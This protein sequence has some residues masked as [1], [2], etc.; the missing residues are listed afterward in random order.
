MK[1]LPPLLRIALVVAALLPARAALA[2]DGLRVG[3]FVETT[4]AGSKLAHPAPDHPVYYEPFIIGYRELGGV[5]TYWQRPPPPPDAVKHALIQAL[6]AQGYQVAPPQ[7]PASLVLVF[8]WGIV[9]PAM[10][11]LLDPK[12]EAV[13]RIEPVNEDAM[14]G[15][16]VGEPWREIYP[17]DNPDAREFIANLHAEESS[18]YFLIISALDARA[19]AQHRQVLLWRAHVT[20]LYWGHYFD[21]VLGTL[22]TTSAPLLGTRMARPQM[23]TVPASPL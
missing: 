5:L 23:L 2:D 17:T 9:D 14:L 6:A 21:Q 19:F 12:D 10:Q 16:L 13:D 7:I 11:P 3:V 8:R 1:K 4:D 15:L 20:T 18:R 22:V